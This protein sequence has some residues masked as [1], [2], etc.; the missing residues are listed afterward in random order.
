VA[1]QWIPSELLFFV[2]IDREKFGVSIQINSSG[3]DVVDDAI[4]PNMIMLGAAAQRVR[5]KIRLSGWIIFK[6]MIVDR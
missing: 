2:E 3:S 5:L 4:N 6:T 1:K